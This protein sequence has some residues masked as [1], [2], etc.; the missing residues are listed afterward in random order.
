ML[1]EI[2]KREHLEILFPPENG[3]P[4]SPSIVNKAHRGK[5]GRSLTVYLSVCLSVV[6]VP[7]V[8]GT[9]ATTCKKGSQTPRATSDLA[10]KF[11]QR[12]P[13]SYNKETGSRS[14]GSTGIMLTV[15]TNY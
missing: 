2:Q 8:T 3:N 12:S 10:R 1:Q 4:L 5:R 15:R 9:R 7:N 11:D 14:K 6:R 13:K